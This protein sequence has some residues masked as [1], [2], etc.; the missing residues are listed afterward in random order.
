VLT[1]TLNDETTK[2]AGTMQ[3][4]QQYFDDPADPFKTVLT[5]NF[6]KAQEKVKALCAQKK[7]CGEKWDIVKTKFHLGQMKSDAF[8]TILDDFFIS[9]DVVLAK[10][11]AFR[12]NWLV[13]AFCTPM[14]PTIDHLMILYD[15]VDPDARAKDQKAANKRKKR[16]PGEG[17]DDGGDSDGAS[18]ELSSEQTPPGSPKG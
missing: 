1:N 8:F 15:L 4:C 12:K 7:L 3:M 6:Q 9:G 17:G 11:E 2:H 18:S 10:P 16:V 14:A 13:P 5:P